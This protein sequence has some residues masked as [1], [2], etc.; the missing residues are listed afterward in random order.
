MKNNEITFEVAGTGKFTAYKDFPQKMFFM[1]KRKE[2]AKILGGRKTLLEL[3]ATAEAYADSDDPVEKKTVEMISWEIMRAS[4]YF[5][6]QLL[7]TEYPKG[8]SWDECS[9]TDFM[10]IWLALDGARGLFPKGEGGENKIPDKTSQ[11]EAGTGA[12]EQGVSE[13][14]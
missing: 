7:I 1:D 12:E 2:I 11:A 8:F 6:C 9:S 5:D 13:K 10:N 14:S 4:K 3:E